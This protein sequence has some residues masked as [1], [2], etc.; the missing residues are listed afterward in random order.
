MKELFL[1]WRYK[2]MVALAGFSAA[3]MA[4]VL[5]PLNHVFV[6]PGPSWLSPAILLP[7]LLGFLFGPAGAWGAALG[8][9][10]ADLF[11]GFGLESLT[12][13]GGTLLLGY[14]PYRLYFLKGRELPLE[15]KQ[16]GRLIAGYLPVAVVGALANSFILGWGASVAGAVSFQEVALSSFLNDLVMAAGIGSLVLVVLVRLFRRWD[17][18]WTSNMRPE[19]AGA[20]SPYAVLGARVLTASVLL[21]FAGCLVASVLGHAMTANILGSVSLAGILTGAV[22]IS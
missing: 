2:K 20:D 11:G 19:D 15:W 12:I 6:L 4:A 5:I 16:S 22:I 21:G 14:I 13:A 9:L 8:S 10:G 1:M 7:P 18:L 17:M 3:L